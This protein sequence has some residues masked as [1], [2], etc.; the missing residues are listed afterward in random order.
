WVVYDSRNG[1]THIGI[2]ST[3]A[4]VN[5]EA[6][7]IKRLYTTP[8]QTEFGPGVGAATFNPVQDRVLFIHGLTNCTKDQPYGFTR[9]TGVSI[10][11]DNP[12]VPIFVD[13][14]DVKPPYTPGALRGGTHAHC[15]S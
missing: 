15:W 11:I 2:T 3:I 12:D 14:R 6:K 13:A 8:N 4:M 7:Q 9:R 5:I 1:D 10:A